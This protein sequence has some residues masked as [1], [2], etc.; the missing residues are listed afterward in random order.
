MSDQATVAQRWMNRS[1]N[2]SIT[3]QSVVRNLCAAT[4]FTAAVFKT[5]ELATQPVAGERWLWIA[6]VNAEIVLAVLLSSGLLPRVTWWSAVATFTAFAFVSGF[7]L[8]NGSQ[9]C[10]CF[11]A[12]AVHPA[13][14]LALDV[15]LLVLLVV[16]RRPQRSSVHA[17]VV[18]SPMRNTLAI[19]VMLSFTLASTIIASTFDPAVLDERGTIVGEHRQV[20]LEP[21]NWAGKQFPLLEHVNVADALRTGHWHVL[22]YHHD[23]PHCQAVLK[24][25]RSAPREERA[26]R[27]VIEVPP[28]AA[29][30]GLPMPE[31]VLVGRLADTH[32]W[33]ITTPTMLTL[34]DGVVISSPEDEVIEG[35]SAIETPKKHQPAQ[36][37]HDLGYIEPNSVHTVEFILANPSDEPVTI[38]NIRPEC[39]CMEPVDPPRVI[40][41]GGFA[42]L[43]VKFVALESAMHYSKQIRVEF[44]GADMRF[45]TLTLRARIGLPLTVAPESLT[46]ADKQVERVVTIRNDGAHP[47]RLLYATSPHPAF[48][49]RVPNTVI[50]PH[51]GTIEIPIRYTPGKSG[52]PPTASIT[53]HTN[54]RTQRTIVYPVS[55]DASTDP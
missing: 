55:R 53:L 18:A 7:H 47:V 48:I 37:I 13:A 43:N 46:F 50:D 54:A 30:A 25:W 20:V 32:R 40:E 26:H 16:Y 9:S 3:G 2:A 49:A 42:I 41:A 38:K 24:Q 44:D 14:T 11:G 33:F 19:G 4:L 45:A 52:T 1:M 27:A 29:N 36:P 39:T 6:L 28:Y 34:S 8:A 12:K 31:G 35:A 17:R 15:I 51:G 21:E 23:C 5:H 10:G 22:I